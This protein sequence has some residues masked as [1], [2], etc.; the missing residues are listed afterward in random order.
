MLNNKNIKQWD[1]RISFLC[2]SQFLYSVYIVI[3]H[4]HIVTLLFVKL[5]KLSNP[6]GKKCFNLS[7]I[8]KLNVN[9]PLSVWRG[10]IT[11]PLNEPGDSK[12][13]LDVQVCKGM[14]L[15][16]S[17]CPLPQSGTISDL[18]IFQSRRKCQWTII[19]IHHGTSCS[20]TYFLLPATGA[21]RYACVV[22]SHC[23]CFFFRADLK[24]GQGI[25]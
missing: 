12:T 14:L 25:M 18:I 20:F 10:L 17:S 15:V 3:V 21:F 23:I 11:A 8:F 13:N 22:A 19:I 16:A 4:L 2:V 1:A 24:E 7:Q 6:T 9:E 5:S